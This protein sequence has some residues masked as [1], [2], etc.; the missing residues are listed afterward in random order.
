MCG[1]R[2]S[3]LLVAR[4]CQKIY[5]NLDSANTHHY[6]AQAPPKFAE[7]GSRRAIRP[8]HPLSPFPTFNSSETNHEKIRVGHCRFLT[9]FSIHRILC[10]SSFRSSVLLLLASAK[11]R[12]AQEVTRSRDGGNNKARADSLISTQILILD[13]T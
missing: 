2:F 3:V 8:K 6:D 13:T 11:H 1:R 7:G 5:L 4:I 10:L 9:A 12:D